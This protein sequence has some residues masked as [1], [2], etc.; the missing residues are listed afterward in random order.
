[1]DILLN[2][3]IFHHVLINCSQVSNPSNRKVQWCTALCD[4]QHSSICMSNHGE[5]QKITPT[6]IVR[7]LPFSSTINGLRC[8]ATCM[9]EYG[10]FESTRDERRKLIPTTMY[11][12]RSNR[13]RS[14]L[15][16]CSN[17][18]LNYRLENPMDRLF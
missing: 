12:V 18:K 16:V 9:D 13:S 10:G 5:R 8:S 4:Y 11:N 3:L 6:K 17:S 2:F 7:F 1:M 14:T 15:R